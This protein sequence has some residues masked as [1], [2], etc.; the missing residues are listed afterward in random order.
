[1]TEA[2]YSQGIE[3]ILNLDGICVS[4]LGAIRH[5]GILMSPRTLSNSQNNN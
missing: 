5:S 3:V 1:M 2:E 4:V